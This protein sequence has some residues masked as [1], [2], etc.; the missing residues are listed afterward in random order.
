MADLITLTPSRPIDWAG[1]ISPGALALFYVSGTTTVAT[2]YQDSAGTIPHAT[3]LVADGNGVF[4]PVFSSQS[5]KVLATDADGVALPGFPLDPAP[6]S[7]TEQSGAALV[8]FDPTESIPDNNVQDAIE[9]VQANQT[10]VLAAAG[11]SVTTAP[12]LANVDATNMTSGRYRYDGTTLGTFPAGV[13]SSDTGTIIISAGASGNAVV[14]L[15]AY[16]GSIRAHRIMQALS[17]GA[18]V[19]NPVGKASTSD[20]ETGTDDAKFMTPLATASAIVALGTPSTTGTSVATTSGTEHGFT[21]LP[22]GISKIEFV[23]DSVSLSGTDN[24][25]VQIGD[26]G[27]YEVAGYSSSSAFN[28]SGSIATDGF[29]VRVGSA[30]REIT[31][32]YTIIRSGVNTWVGAFSGADTAAA[33]Y[34]TSGSRKALSAEFDRIRL[35]ASGA[36][37]F[38][39]GSVNIIYS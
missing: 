25:L 16:D 39:N 15:T 20:A 1:D 32:I 17:W 9:R 8:S 19:F 38:D 7:A 5:L 27:G 23:F 31:G 3:P 34:I 14:E 29:L 6:R 35:I 37:T 11:V 21:G 10:T 22:A 30:T 26:A 28:G 36:D 13:T 18:W 2:V 12:L 4:P 33:S 24:L